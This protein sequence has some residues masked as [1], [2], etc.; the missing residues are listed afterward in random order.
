[1]AASSEA[2]GVM[3]GKRPEQYHTDPADVGASEHKWRHEGH[4]EVERLAREEEDQPA[5]TKETSKIP[6]S[7]VNPALRELRK[8]RGAKDSPPLEG[9]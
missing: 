2:E 5:E 6:K 9:E 3:A 1:M 4:N 8:K 7:G